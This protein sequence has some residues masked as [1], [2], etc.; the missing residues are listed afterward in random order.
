[1]SIETN[2]ENIPPPVAKANR[3][4]H[5]EGLRGIAILSVVLFHYFKAFPNGYY[6]V[7]IFLVISGYMLFR[8]FWKKDEGFS[9]FSYI[10]KKVARLW[11]ATICITLP[12]VVLAMF[13]LSNGTAQETLR[14][15]IATLLSGANIFYDY[16]ADGYFTAIDTIGHPLVHTWYLSLIAQIYLICGVLYW[17]CK[18]LSNKAK[19]VVFLV[20]IICSCSICYLPSLWSLVTPLHEK[21]S[22]YYW[23]SGRLWIVL[24][25]GFVP[26]MPKLQAARITRSVMA[27]TSLAG[28]LVIALLLPKCSCPGLVEVLAI[29]GSMLCLKYG[30][31]GICAAALENR[32][33]L[34][35][36]KYSFSLYLVHWPILVFFAAYSL[37]WE[38]SIW[39]KLVAIACSF[40]AAFLFYHTVEKHRFPTTWTCVAWIASLAFTYCAT[41]NFLRIK[42]HLHIENHDILSKTFNETPGLIKKEIK[43][44]KLY[45]T[46]PNFRRMN[47]KGGV[48]NHLFSLENV[49]LLYSIGETD[50]EANF[51]L[52]GDSHAEV[53]TGALDR[54]ARKHNWHGAFLNL[55]VVPIENYFYEGIYCQCWD[56]EKAGLL[57]SYLREN[58]Q[59]DTVIV[60]CHWTNKPSHSYYDW[61]GVS[62]NPAP[63]QA[64][65]KGI[66]DYFVRIRDCGVKILVFADVPRFY[67]I[68]NPL[69]Y[70]S[71]HTMLNAPLDEELFICTKEEYNA[72]NKKVNDCLA[73]MEEEGICKVVHLEKFFFKDGPAR[74]YKDG[75]FYFRDTNHMTPVG[76]VKALEAV[77]E[78]L[79]AA[80]D[81]PGQPAKS[82]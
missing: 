51:L 24:A 56:R 79:G 13:M 42:Y 16:N 67:K 1:M 58:P 71:K 52:I 46:L 63:P 22:T 34:S 32:L 18:S 78:E 49:P 54:L 43:S 76:A 72:H 62:V 11:P 40:L 59:I 55:Y 61:D 37:T 68:S 33:I 39:I 82:E 66:R 10:G 29:I 30:N 19:I 73:Q 14:A 65:C 31:C 4:R 21:F 53:L 48:M 2:K 38:D 57:L 6:G 36:G 50:R 7:D 47:Y 5:V 3:M 27:G 12:C 80:L 81:N 41:A 77:E 8:N 23:T 9:L 75:I 69:S 45:Q 64:F 25:G 74:L 70:V 26:L 17:L 20:C 28:L 60:S 15:G 44:G 35:V